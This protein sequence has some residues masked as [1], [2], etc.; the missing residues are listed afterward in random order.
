MYWN[1]RLIFVMLELCLSVWS[2]GF[3]NSPDGGGLLRMP[4]QQLIGTEQR[5]EGVGRGSEGEGGEQEVRLLSRK[6][7]AVVNGRA[8]SS[9]DQSPFLSPPSHQVP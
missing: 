2:G 1:G 6:S 3:A 9:G 8:A 4:G 7:A 5:C